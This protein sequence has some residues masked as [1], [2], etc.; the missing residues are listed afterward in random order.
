[1]AAAPAG[2][3]S[4]RIGIAAL[5]AVGRLPG[6]R[7]IGALLGMLAYAAAPRRRRI[8]A[9]NLRLTMPHLPPPARRRLL[10]RHFIGLGEWFMDNMWALSASPQ[11]LRRCIKL[12]GDAPPP[13]ILL[14]PHFL[15]MELALL[16][17]NVEFPE[18]R[19]AYHYKPLHND[20]WDVVSRRLRDRFGSSG[21]SAVS[22]HSLL[23]AV[24]HCRGGGALCYLPDIDTRGRKSTVY[25]PFMAVEETAT[26]T[27]PARLAKAAQ[28]A[29]T[30]YIIC[31]QRG[32]GGGGYVGKILPP[33][34]NF[35]SGDE[36]ADAARINAL[37]AE[38]VDAMPENYY[39]LHRRFKT[40][41]KGETGHYEK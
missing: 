25:V 34:E 18:L 31:R 37:I 15:G 3:L 8:A 20:F 6:R 28:A 12:E 39:W 17:L 41:R 32:G 26:T 27:G 19:I 5:V 36:T 1:M 10:R 14:M 9:V 29:V 24:R 21:F 2:R 11:A 7:A 22:R 16:R 4:H 13:G 38:W 30:P 33:L 35:P 23:A 40:N